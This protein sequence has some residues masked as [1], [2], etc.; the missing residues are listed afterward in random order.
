MHTRFV[1]PFLAAAL[2]AVEASSMVA[3]QPDTTARRDTTVARDTASVSDTARAP[4][5]LQPVVVEATRTR[6]NLT[7]VPQAVSE[8]GIDQIQRGRREAGLDEVLEG[9]PGVIA[10]DRGNYSNSGGLRLAIRGDLP[11]VQLLQDGVPLTMA[12]GTTEPNNIDLG[13]AGSIEVIRGPSSVLYGN[14]GGGVVS[15]T[16]Q[17]PAGA[18]L[19]VHPG[20]QFGSNG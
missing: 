9:I 3:Q 19:V 14:S 15:V 5:R 7:R 10:E 1:V 2:V 6:Q 12:D 17:F 11:G 4:Q 8:V 18:P 16:T 20:I 13:S